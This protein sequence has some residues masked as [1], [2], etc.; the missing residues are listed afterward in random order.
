LLDQLEGAEAVRRKLPASVQVTP[1]RDGVIAQAGPV[2]PV[3]DVNKQDQDIE[4]LRALHRA[5]QPVILSEWFHS[6][7]ILGVDRDTASAWLHR[8][9]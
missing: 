5:I 2:P 1:F 9:D 7:N 3:G 4:P 8:F 6:Y